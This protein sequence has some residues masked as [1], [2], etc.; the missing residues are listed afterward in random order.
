MVVRLVVFIWGV[1]LWG[2]GVWIRV[3]VIFFCLRGIVRFGWVMRFCEY[4]ESFGRVGGGVGRFLVSV[5]LGGVGFG[6]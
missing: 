4:L 5:G 1:V 6:E 2:S 3:I